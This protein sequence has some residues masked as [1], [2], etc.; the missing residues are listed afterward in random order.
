MLR[1]YAFLA[2]LW[3]GSTCQAGVLSLSELLDYVDTAP[4]VRVVEAELSAL[5]ALKQ[6]REAEAGW[7]WFAS[8]GTGR[9]R[10]LITEDLRDDYYGRNLALGLRYPLL[11]SLH[12]QLAAVSVVESE[13][14]Q[15]QARRYLYRAQQRLALRSAYADWW[16]AQQEQLWC[17]KHVDRAQRSRSQLAERLRGGWLLASEA[18]LLDSRWQS[19]Q[20]RCSGIDVVLDE[21]RFNLQTLSGQLVETRHQAAA[22]MLSAKA[23]PLSAWLGYLET[24]PRLQERREQLR[25]AEQNRQS[26]WYAGI[27]SSFSVSQS[28]EDRSGGA[29]PGNGLVASI[30]LSTPLDP[31]SYG[32]ARSDQSEARHQAAMAQLEAD[33][34]QLVQALGQ[35]LRAHRQAAD[36]L[37]EARQRLEVAALAVREQALRLEGNVDQAYLGTMT[38]ELEHGYSELRLVAAWHELWLQQAALQLFLDNGEHQSLLGPVQLG[39]QEIQIAAGPVPAARLKNWRRGTYV[40]D[41]SRLLDG[42]SRA[43]ELGS[44][45]QAG[46]QR[47]YLGISAEQ[48]AAPELLRAQLQTTLGEARA[49]GLEVVLLLGDPHWM[50]PTGRQALIDLLAS[51]NSLPFSALHLD[52]EVEQ[53]G[54]PVPEARLRDW[55]DTLAEVRRV[56]SWPLEISS[57]HRWFAAPR[58]GEPCVP[59]RLDQRGIRQV[60]LMI[61]TRNP[62]RSAEL[63][64]GIARRWPGLSFRLAQSVEPQLATEE[65]WNGVPRKQLEVQEK[66][67]R[68]RLQAASISG[69]DWQDWSNYPH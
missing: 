61:Y 32:R 47:I 59:C 10:E 9:Y 14:Q 53:L 33:R 58:P 25:L 23:Q 66:S 31:L 44:L 55:L 69:I 3:V 35:A 7:Q 26:P 68:Q 21:T 6:Q 37:P 12:R 40:W 63:A 11:G 30:S 29:K 62:E 5:N 4:A 52:L 19:V 54:W 36:A 45:R 60:S 56:S 51:L 46:M 41:S 1:S 38:A 50:L 39:W 64:E 42:R 27:D 13:Q 20:R 22:E 28:Y 65:T 48:L 15:Q 24:H 34:E 8:A 49:L 57:H 18:R 43:S 2:L 17:A 67:W 16:R